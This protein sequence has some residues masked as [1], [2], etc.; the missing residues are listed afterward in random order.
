MGYRNG[1]FDRLSKTSYTDI[2]PFDDK[3]AKTWYKIG[4]RAGWGSI[5]E[6]LAKESKIQIK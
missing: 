3:D 2:S 6:S 5:I 1:K 4:Y